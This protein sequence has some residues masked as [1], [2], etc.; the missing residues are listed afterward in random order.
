M[1][2]L[3]KSQFP[4]RLITI[5]GPDGTGKSTQIELLCEHLR[6][7]GHPV[8]KYDFPHKMGTPIGDLIGS[9]LKGKFGDVTPEFLALAF[10][11]D[12][13][14]SRT[15]LL[16]DLEAGRTVI[17]DRYVRSNIAFQRAKTDSDDR[18]EELEVLLIW[19]EYTL[20][21]LP[22]PDLE[23]VLF[24]N[25]H[26]FS[27]GQHLRRQA[28]HGRQYIGQE[29]DIHE[30]ATNLQMAVNNYYATLPLSNRLK[31]LSIFDSRNG[32]LAVPDLHA[33]I[34]RVIAP[35]IEPPR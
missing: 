32:R 5:E 33:M 28:D 26:Y 6:S 12:R 19:I 23:V 30:D 21:Q 17:C 35:Y 18:R 22:V 4:G 11:V 2:P 16:A 9:F 27:D 1:S 10:A 31:K 29:A 15:R 25:D 24:A 14:E 20:F 8:V 7:M 13:L 34:L 3:N